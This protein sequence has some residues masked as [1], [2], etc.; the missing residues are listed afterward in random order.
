[1]R[2]TVCECERSDEPSIAQALHLLNSPEIAD[3]VGSR[4]GIAQKLANSDL[5]DD[6]IIEELYLNTVS[7]FPEEVDRQ[8]MLQAFGDLDTDRKAATEDVLW[9]LLN[10]KEY[11]FNH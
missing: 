5:S 4:H 3:K 6:E 8:S 2:A 7:R 11:L 1:V 10:S 9:A